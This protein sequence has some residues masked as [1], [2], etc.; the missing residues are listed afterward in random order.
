MGRKIITVDISNFE[1]RKQEIASQL[2][3]ASKDVGFFYIGGAKVGTLHFQS[4][5]V[6]LST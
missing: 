1:E 2:L 6:Q 3:K 4:I 5:E